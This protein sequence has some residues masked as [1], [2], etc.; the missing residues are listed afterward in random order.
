MWVKDTLPPRVR[1]KW[2]LM[3]MRLSI[4]NF[5]GIVRTLVAVGTEIDV[6]MFDARAFAIPLSGVTT[7]SVV[8]SD[9]RDA[10]GAWAGMGALAGAT[11]VVRA[12]G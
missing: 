7:D 9:G 10:V 3:T 2:L 12:A 8:S 1:R 4:I 5:A 11:D 6:S